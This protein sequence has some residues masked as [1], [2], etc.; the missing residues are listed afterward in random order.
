VKSHYFY[1]NLQTWINENPILAKSFGS[2]HAAV[3]FVMQDQSPGY[4]MSCS[5][6]ASKSAGMVAPGTVRNVC[7]EL[8]KCKLLQRRK[9]FSG[10]EY[11]FS[12]GL[13]L[14]YDPQLS[15]LSPRLASVRDKYMYS[16]M[17][18]KYAGDQWSERDAGKALREATEDDVVSVGDY[19][20]IVRSVDYR[21]FRSEGYLR[22]V[23]YE[24]FVDRIVEEL[25]SV[26]AQ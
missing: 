9:V 13:L 20:Q 1:S 15:P 26:A 23:G 14:K 21:V 18:L 25:L 16:L 7:T 8:H 4:W 24:V 6:I 19:E 10:Y 11:N 17:Q 2:A 3:L 22:K 5:V 12:L